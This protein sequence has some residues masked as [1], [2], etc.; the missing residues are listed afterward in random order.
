MR[1][2]PGQVEGSGAQL[3]DYIECKD[4]KEARKADY[5]T[6]GVVSVTTVQQQL[7]QRLSG[8]GFSCRIDVI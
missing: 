5:E 6:S 1:G 3:L 4:Q 2:I 8:S 7:N